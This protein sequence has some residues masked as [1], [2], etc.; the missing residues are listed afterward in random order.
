MEEMTKF[1]KIMATLERYALK[2]AIAIHYFSILCIGAGIILVIEYGFDAEFIIL[3][4][5]A[6]F[7]SCCTF[8]KIK[9]DTNDTK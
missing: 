1:E 6:I 4:I 5:M 9:E 8:I 2:I 3:I 7:L